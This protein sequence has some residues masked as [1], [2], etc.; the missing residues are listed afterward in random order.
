VVSVGE[1]QAELQTSQII[2]K[3]SQSI[4]THVR[5]VFVDGYNAQM[6]I[7]TGIAATRLLAAAS[8]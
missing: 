2:D 7:I 8:M 1:I 3:F 6:R 5:K 4:Q